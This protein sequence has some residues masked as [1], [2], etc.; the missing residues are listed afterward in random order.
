MKLLYVRQEYC[1]KLVDVRQENFDVFN[2][3]IEIY[4]FLT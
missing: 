2:S 1:I 3:Y 4:V